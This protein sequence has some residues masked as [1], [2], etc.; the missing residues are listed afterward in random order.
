MKQINPIAI[1]GQGTSK[2]AIILNAYAV[3]VQL[4]SSATFYYALLSENKEALAQGN[5]TMSGEDYQAWESDDVAWS[6]IASQLNLTI[7]GDWVEP[8][9]EPVVEENLE[10]L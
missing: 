2:D 5:L 6:F 4:G 10:E 3:N 9:V 7:V 8:V 1:W